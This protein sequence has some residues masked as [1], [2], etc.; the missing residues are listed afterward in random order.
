MYDLTK[1][2]ELILISIWKLKNNAYGVTIKNDFIDTT[3]KSITYGSLCK[4]LYKLVQKGYIESNESTPVSQQGGRRK[5]MYY[6]T[7]D[8]KTALKHAYKVQ[9]S[10]WNSISDLFIEFE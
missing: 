1:H 2:E 9:K 8:G 7:Y 5:V 4:T 10:A 3:G 6:L